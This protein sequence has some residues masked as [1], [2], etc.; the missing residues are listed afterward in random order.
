M[1]VGPA[2]FDISTHVAYYPP[3]QRR[4]VLERYTQAMADR[5]FPFADDLDWDLLVATFEAGRLAN[6]IIWVARGILEG[7]GWTFRELAAWRDALAAVVAG[8]G[9]AP[10]GKTGT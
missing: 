7:N 1:G 8:D 5:G 2:G 10:A 4:F 3:A 6:Q 9:A